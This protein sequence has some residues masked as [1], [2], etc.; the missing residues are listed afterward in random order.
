MQEDKEKSKRV[1]VL[2]TEFTGADQICEA[3][4]E[5]GRTVIWE[6]QD[7]VDYDSDVV[8]GGALITQKWE[9]IAESYPD[10]TFL[11][12]IDKDQIWLNDLEAW[13]AEIE[14][15]IKEGN[16]TPDVFKHPLLGDLRRR[17]G[18]IL[19]SY[20]KVCSRIIRDLT[21]KKINLHILYKDSADSFSA[22]NNIFGIR[23]E[24]PK[25]DS[26]RGFGTRAIRLWQERKRWIQ[27][28]RLL[29][30][31]ERI[32]EIYDEYCAPCEHFNKDTCGVCGCRIKRKGTF[33]NKLAWATTECPVQKWKA[34]EEAVYALERKEE[35][36]MDKAGGIFS[37]NV[38]RAPKKK[39]CCG[40]K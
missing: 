31:D 7:D 34:E 38:V 27:S 19:R 36:N 11:L 22:L 13:V 18:E 23:L 25:V 5:T 26:T 15:I 35:E 20:R 1:I 14:P 17:S 2:G 28:G 21:K 30:T 6:Y 39:G 3:V 29:R 16:L 10:A 12:V 8:I 37:R 33:L 4:E 24:E 40:G 9:E 32:E